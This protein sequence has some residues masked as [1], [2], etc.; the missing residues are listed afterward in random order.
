MLTA[1]Y[2]PYIN[3]NLDNVD[4]LDKILDG[5]DHLQLGLVVKRQQLY[6]EMRL[7]RGSRGVGNRL[8][9]MMYAYV[10]ACID[11]FDCMNV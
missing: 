1:I 2:R 4:A 9:G 7:G 8:D 11:L 3:T 6:T 5:L 10:N